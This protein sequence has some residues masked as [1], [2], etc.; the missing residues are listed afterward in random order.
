MEQLTSAGLKGK[1]FPPKVSVRPTPLLFIHG[2]FADHTGF[3]KIAS[4]FADDGYHAYTFSRRGRLGQLPENANGL[5]F[6]DYL[7]DTLSVINNIKPTPVLIGHSLGGLLAMKAAEETQNVPA[8][9]LINTAP[10][11]M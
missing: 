4:L 5:T 7:Q 10:P 3:D 1:Y 11:G 6:D 2:A 9:V 8:L